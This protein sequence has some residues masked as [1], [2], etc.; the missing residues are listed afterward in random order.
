MKRRQGSR[1]FRVISTV[2]FSLLLFNTIALNY[3]KKEGP[4]RRVLNVFERI[5]LGKSSGSSTTTRY[6]TTTTYSVTGDSASPCVVDP[7]QLP[8]PPPP[9]K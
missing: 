2:V 3:P 6:S 4:M 7:L 9:P 5:F 1:L 8:P